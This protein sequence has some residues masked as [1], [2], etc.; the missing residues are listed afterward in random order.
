M[1]FGLVSSRKLFNEL[2]VL[3][4]VC[5]ELYTKMINFECL[6]YVDDKYSLKFIRNLFSETCNIFGHNDIGEI[7]SISEILFNIHLILNYNHRF[8]D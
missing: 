8:V 4:P 7:W 1:R 3:Q 5:K 2:K 6:S